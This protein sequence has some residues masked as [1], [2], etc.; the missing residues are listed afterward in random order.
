MPLF[1]D[2]EQLQESVTVGSD[3]TLKT[4]KPSILQAELKFILPIVGRPFYEDLQANLGNSNYEPVLQLARSALANLALS[5]FVITGG[6]MIDNAG[7]YFL[8]TNEMWRLSDKDK[9]DL[10][11]SFYEAGMNALDELLLYLASNS[12]SG[13]LPTFQTIW[14]NSEQRTR[15]NSLLIKS[16]IDFNQHVQT[17]RSRATFASL[18]DLLAYV[19]RDRIQPVVNGY[20]PALLALNMQTAT[21][22]EKKIHEAAANALAL[23]TVAKALRMGNYTRAEYGFQAVPNMVQNNENQIFE[24]ETDGFAALDRLRTLLETQLPAGYVPLPVEQ[25]PLVRSQTAK[26]VLA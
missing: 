18:Y 9:A 7:I 2:I 5:L 19:Q 6:A 14:N 15:Y 25:S 16:A 8:K 22:D 10:Q 12:P 26:I 21:V 13:T 4:L 11:K 17:F 24:Y 20:F 23:F 3:L 1:Q